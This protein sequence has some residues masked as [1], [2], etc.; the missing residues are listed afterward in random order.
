MYARAIESF[1]EIRNREA[2]ITTWF[3]QNFSQAKINLGPLYLRPT[4]ALI[5]QE[6]FEKAP[7]PHGVALCDGNFRQTEKRS[8]M[9]RRQHEG[10]PKS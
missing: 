8:G 1:L 3:L 6:I 5:A 10:L 7:R 9:S 4:M 2:W